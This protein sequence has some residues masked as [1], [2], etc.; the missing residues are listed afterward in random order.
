MA[1]IKNLNSK[2][3]KEPHRLW[4]G[5][6]SGEVDPIMVRM[7]QSIDLD[8]KIYKEDLLGSAAHAKML[9]SIGILTESE[10]SSILTSL[11]Q[12]KSEIEAGEM[13]LHHELEDIHTH[14]EN[15]LVELIGSTGKKLHTAR[16]RNDQV[17]VD[18]HLHVI[19][20]SVMIAEKLYEL[21]SALLKRASESTDIVLPGYT[22][23]QVAQ[24]VR[25]SHHLLS[26][27]WAFFRDLERFLRTA[28]YARVLPLGSGAMAGVNY[29]T[30]REMIRKELDF[31]SIYP[32]S[33]DAVS[34]RDHILEF[35]HSGSVFAV[36]SSRISEEIILW[37]SV[38]FG[39]IEL[40]DFLTT[41]SSI[42]PQKKNPDL[43]ELSRGK[44]GRIIANHI[45]LL[46]N[47]KGLPLT[48]N[49]DLQEDRFPLLDNGE[50]L[51]LIL[52]SLTAMVSHMVFKK[53][54]MR[55]SLE[56]GYATATD[57]ADALVLKR[58]IPF[59]EAHH[60]VGK[61][62]AVCSEKNYFLSNVPADLREE[63]HPVLA[64]DSFY[65]PAIDLL[66]SADKKVSYG[67]T[68]LHRQEEQL[69]EATERLAYS[70]NAIESLRHFL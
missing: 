52:D 60:Y 47:I 26:H 2:E 24:P 59:R 69:K 14:I 31:K 62:V 53:T 25:L 11:D 8:I 7:G 57:L 56:A 1:G 5:R 54:N 63:I 27:F 43:A 68:A 17:A 19:R 29:S 48:Y 64:D 33:M 20:S 23:L 55:K 10:L 22:H 16:S 44:T 45:N 34:S 30:D 39:F 36:H 41:G 32:N 15:R 21:C 66:T 67:G 40:P 61:L 51:N 3:K 12:I 13:Q 65:L 18:T 38:E 70:K 49:R 28:E 37:N 9:S 35:L 42:M 6:S 50:Q 46:I 4:Q 58:N